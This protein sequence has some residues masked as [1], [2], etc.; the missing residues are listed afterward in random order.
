VLQTSRQD[1]QGAD[2]PREEESW[3]RDH[4]GPGSLRLPHGGVA[5]REASGA[6][7]TS[8][9]PALRRR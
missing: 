7:V 1:R 6:K 2:R 9:S 8:R 5:A 4:R 3:R